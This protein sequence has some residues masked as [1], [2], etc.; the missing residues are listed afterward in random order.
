MEKPVINLRIE[1]LIGQFVVVNVPSDRDKNLNQSLQ[2]LTE[3]VNEALVSALS[4][5]TISTD[6][7]KETPQKDCSENAVQN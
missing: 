4:T 5:V 3:A 6:N 7:E 1:N 2:H